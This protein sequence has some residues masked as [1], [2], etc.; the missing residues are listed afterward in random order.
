MSNDS[1][2][3]NDDLKNSMGRRVLVYLIRLAAM[4]IIGGAILFGIS[5]RLDWAG[6]W[7]L[8]GISAATQLIG[9]WVIFATD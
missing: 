3:P 6:A 8:L 2:L 5:W 7:L 9:L 1:G 4:L